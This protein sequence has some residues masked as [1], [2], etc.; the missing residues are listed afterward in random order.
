[1]NMKKVFS[2]VLATSLTMSFVTAFSASAV[3]ADSGEVSMPTTYSSYTPA[4]AAANGS[5]V[6]GD[7]TDPKILSATTAP[8]SISNGIITLDTINPNQTFYIYLGADGT[9]TWSSPAN[10]NGSKIYA[11]DLGN[12]DLFSIKVEKDGD[13]KTLIKSI[14]QIAN[15]NF[16][17]V[18]GR[19]TYLKVVLGDTTTTSDLKANAKITFKAR[20]DSTATN[21]AVG[22]FKSGDSIVLDLKMWINN[23]NGGENPNTG[24]RVYFDPVKNDTNTIVWGDDRAALKFDADSDTSKFYARLST[25]N[26]SSIYAEY[27]DPV[28]ADLWF[29]DF[30]SNPYVPSTSRATLTLG[31]PWEDDASYLP[32]PTECFIYQKDADGNLTDVTSLFTYSEDDQEIAGWS[33]KT[34]QLGTYIISDSELDIEV[35]DDVDELPDDTTDVTVPE[36]DKAIP[37]TGSSDM[38]NVAVAAAIASLAVAGVV[39]FRK[40]SK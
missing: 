34:R 3:V 24:D 7:T 25:K 32:D 10:A 2:A 23:T 6:S 35:Y 36:G 16:G 39:A 9:T 15:K 12:K 4:Q 11:Q 37:D 26:D 14:E 31:I 20:K 40:S 8:I 17:N 18:V 5:V 22:N 21:G 33:I 13:G 28:N 30:V 38:V 29:Y 27:G 1:M 19:G